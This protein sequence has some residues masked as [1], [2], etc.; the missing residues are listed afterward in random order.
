M[1][2]K[3]GMLFIIIAM[4]LFCFLLCKYVPLFLDYAKSKKLYN[5]IEEEYVTPDTEPDNSQEAQMEAL[6]LGIDHKKNEFAPI[7][8]DGEALL[9]ENADYIGWI[10]APK[11]DIS[12]PVVQS[13]DNSDYLHTDFYRNYSFPGT[14][15]MDCRCLS[16]VLSHH[17]IL[18]GHNMNNGTM[19]AGL[20]SYRDQQFAEEHPVFWFITPKY[21]LLYKVFAVCNANPYDSV[22]YGVDGTDYRN[23]QEF[24]DAMNAIKSNSIVSIES[25]IKSTDYVMSLSTCTEN[26]S[27]R[28]IVHG[29]L[30]GSVG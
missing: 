28:C 2:K 12:Y 20:K 21:K 4:L 16:G 8:V 11:T 29:I 14:V 7:D 18:Y 26:S 30:L 25:D 1:R 17:S 5:E 24:L 3:L 6:L 22:E 9:D 10:Y 19:F 13:R 27:V 15:F 23:N